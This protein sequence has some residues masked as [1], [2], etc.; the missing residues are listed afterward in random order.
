[1]LD[2]SYK[3][4]LVS[5][6]VT[7]SFFNLNKRRRNLIQAN[8]ITSMIGLKGRVQVVAKLYDPFNITEKFEFKYRNP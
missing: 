1:M 4:E 8:K 2:G 6:L 3:F 5:S 7:R